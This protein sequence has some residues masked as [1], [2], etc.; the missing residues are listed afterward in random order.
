MP[1]SSY[2][3][4][5]KVQCCPRGD[6]STSGKRHGGPLAPRGTATVIVAPRRQ[7]ACALHWGR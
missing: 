7:Q 4:S 3:R 6:V 2:F 1:T 5:A